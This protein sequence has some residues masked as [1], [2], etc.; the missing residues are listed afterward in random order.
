MPPEE[1]TLVQPVADTTPPVVTQPAEIDMDD[2]EVEAARAA[3]EKPAEP[4]ATEAKPAATTTTAP[5]ETPAETPEDPDEARIPKWRFDEAVGKEREAR[6][7]AEGELAAYQK[8]MTQRIAATGGNQP[9]PKTADE[10]LRDIKAERL[11]VAAKF[12]NGEINAGQWAEALEALSDREFA[13]REERMAARH[14]QVPQA[15]VVADDMRLDEKTMELADQHPYVDLLTDDQ[16]RHLHGI[17]VLELRMEG[18]TLPDNV[19]LP[20]AERFAL[21]ERIAELSDRYGQQMTGK[22]LEQ[23]KGKPAQ[24]TAPAKPALSPIALS[25]QQKLEQARDAPPN[26]N[27]ISGTPSSTEP[28]E[29]QIAAMNEE[30]IIAR[31][32]KAARDRMMGLA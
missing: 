6:A 5:T 3:L 30:D 23:L 31:I 26:L 32:P 4:Q 19:I 12:D 1:Q 2:A 7:R 28:T 29:D 20:P 14:Q 17:A 27:S 18:R 11:A 9:A 24:P 13:I 22:T 15:P 10:Q 21:R 16:V 25:R 8:L